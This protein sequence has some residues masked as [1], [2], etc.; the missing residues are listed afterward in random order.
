MGMIKSGAVETDMTLLL[1]GNSVI[2]AQLRTDLVYLICLRN[3]LDRAQSQI[4]FFVFKDLF[5]FYLGN[6]FWVTI[7]YKYHGKS[8]QCFIL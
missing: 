6:M 3:Y 7:Q 2:G 4:F 1:D 8:E 5:S